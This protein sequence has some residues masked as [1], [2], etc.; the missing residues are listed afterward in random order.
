MFKKIDKII[1]LLQV[2]SYKSAK[3]ILY[4]LNITTDI[5]F[6]YIMDDIES[7]ATLNCLINWRKF[8]E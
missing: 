4:H 7:E 6:N 5:N 3:H 1:Y 8:Y 2:R